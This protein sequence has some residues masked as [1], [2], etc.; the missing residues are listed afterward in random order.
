MRRASAASAQSAPDWYEDSILLDLVTLLH[1]NLMADV[2]IDYIAG[3][4]RFDSLIKAMFPDSVVPYFSMCSGTGIDS[5]VH[6][7]LSKY[8]E[9]QYGVS[10]R[11]QDVGVCERNEKK[12]KWLRAQHVDLSCLVHDLSEMA[13]H[14]VKNILDPDHH[15][16]E[17]FPY[18]FD[19]GAGWPCTSLTSLNANSKDNVGSVQEES[20]ES[21][22]AFALVRQ[23]VITH[24]P[25]LFTMENVC[26][27][28]KVGASGLS[29]AEWVR[30][31]MMEL[32]Y[33][34]LFFVLSNRDYGS[35]P[36]RMRVW[37]VCAKNLKGA[38]EEID[39]F[40]MSIITGAKVRTGEEIIDR[41]R[42]LFMEPKAR[43]AICRKLRIPT[44]IGTG[45]RKSKTEEKDDPGWRTSCLD[46]FELFG[47]PWPPCFDDKQYKHIS[48]EGLL[49]REAFTCLLYDQA[50][51]LQDD[52]E[53]L[54]LNPKVERVIMSPRH[55][56]EL[57]E[58][59]L[60]KPPD[61]A[62]IKGRAKI[63]H[64]PWHSHPG[65]IV[66]GTT[67][68]VRTRSPRRTRAL[69]HLEYMSMM[70]WCPAQWERESPDPSASQ[71]AQALHFVFV[72]RV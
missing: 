4:Q 49:P 53:F 25:E 3:I 35:L 26:N 42:Y 63:N 43:K 44:V 67:L 61:N 70:G 27:V 60:K 54:D 9:R 21:G 15:C 24:C 30:R 47:I 18:V 71:D 23:A 65:T 48:T 32:G 33:W 16:F 1:S 50:F 72:C 56:E 29:D 69:E 17:G 36:E 2:E 57:T 38:V 8:W 52:M 6:R 51:P 19:G 28:L 62:V 20:S 40:F 22:R 13:E 34:C 11:W 5:R 68:L 7:A 39:R 10:F 12:Q 59:E 66:G 37:W 41:S 64:T 31:S 45:P 55:F 46:M 58:Q 14:V